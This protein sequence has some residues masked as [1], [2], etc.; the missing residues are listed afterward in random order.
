MK[1]SQHWRSQWGW[2]PRAPLPVRAAKSAAPPSTPVEITG[3]SP[4]PK[5]GDIARSFGD[6][7]S[8]RAAAEQF[9]LDSKSKRSKSAMSLDEL[10]NQQ[11]DKH[12]LP[13]IVKADTHGSLEAICSILETLELEDDIELDIIDSQVGSI[14]SSDVNLAASANAEIIAFHVNVETTAKKLMEQ[15]AIEAAQ[16]KIIY[17]LVD[18]V[19][20]RLRRL[21]GPIMK[22]VN[23]GFAAVKAVFRSSKFGQIAGCGVTE[24]LITRGKLARVTRGDKVLFEGEIASIKREKETLTEARKG[25]ECGLGLKGFSECD[26]GDVIECYEL[27]EDV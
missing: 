13:L 24:G 5:A 19:K 12:K 10:L 2:S 25:T 7:K 6:E 27:E 1:R 8:A 18:H 17:Q 23:L 22:E 9:I 16:F 3:I 21:K 26:V 20:D 15:Q 14:N 4:L 11:S